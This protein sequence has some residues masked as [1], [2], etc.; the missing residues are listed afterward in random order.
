MGG[1]EAF[2][3]RINGLYLLLDMALRG[4]DNCCRVKACKVLPTS[5]G[6]WLQFGKGS[7]LERF[8]KV[9]FLS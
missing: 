6:M 1:S 9:L 8:R 2:D 7:L 4:A 5:R 3:A